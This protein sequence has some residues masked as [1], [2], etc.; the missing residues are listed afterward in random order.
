MCQNCFFIGYYC[1]EE[2]FGLPSTMMLPATKRYLN[3]TMHLFFVFHESALASVA[4]GTP[5]DAGL[6]LRGALVHVL[7]RRRGST[8]IRYTGLEPSPV[9]AFVSPTTVGSGR[10]ES[11]WTRW[12]GVLTTSP[13]ESGNNV[14][15]L[16]TR[17]GQ[18]EIGLRH[19]LIMILKGSQCR[20]TLNGKNGD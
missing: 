9:C 8:T 11:P 18:G 19:G 14:H 3:R 13:S 2:L 20:H 1:T 12:W 10:G 4:T 16:G 6:E 5:V 15:C 17:D 7:I